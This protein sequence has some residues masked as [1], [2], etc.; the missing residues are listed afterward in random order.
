[1]EGGKKGSYIVKNWHWQRMSYR[2]DE[3][4]LSTTKRRGDMP[5]VKI[6]KGDRIF[7]NR[8]IGETKKGKAVPQAK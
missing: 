1:L 6:T 4:T 5:L 8:E 7:E 3:S 2:A